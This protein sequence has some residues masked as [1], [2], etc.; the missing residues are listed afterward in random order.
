MR[1]KIYMQSFRYDML[2]AS[3]WW[4]YFAYRAQNRINEQLVYIPTVMTYLR[5]KQIFYI[6]FCLKGLS[7]SMM[8]SSNG[9]IFR[10][11]G[12]LC[13]E[14]T[15]HRWIVSHH[16]FSLVFV[17]SYITVTSQ[18]ARWRLKSPVSLFLFGQPFVQAQIKK[19]QSSAWL[20]FVRGILR[21]PVDS[22]HKGSSNAEKCFHLMTS[23]CWQRIVSWIKCRS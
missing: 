16:W 11:T 18:W 15:G 22:P 7:W 19:K 13:G 14:F 23:S 20:A 6:K 1:N 10:V 12:H 17:A 9:S 8:T 3:S 21:W 4:F 2:Y 5:T